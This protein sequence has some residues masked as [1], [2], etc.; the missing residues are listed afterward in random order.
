MNHFIVTICR[1]ITF[2]F[3]EV[4]KQT[5]QN[6]P[7]AYRF[8]TSLFVEVLKRGRFSPAIAG[9]FITFLFGEVLKPQGVIGAWN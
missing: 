9:W 8:I 2:L 7:Q 1:V 4:L 3:G 5:N 6:R